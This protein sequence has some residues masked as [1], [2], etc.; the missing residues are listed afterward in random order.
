[1]TLQKEG[2]MS[3]GRLYARMY[4]L[5]QMTYPVLMLCLDWLYLLN[6]AKISEKGEITLC[7]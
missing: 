1:M 6:A 5:E 3:I 4:E 7:I 2:N